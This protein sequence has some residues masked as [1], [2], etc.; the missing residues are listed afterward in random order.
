MIERFISRKGLYR[1]SMLLT[2]LMMSVQLMAQSPNAIIN[3]VNK[4]FARVHDYTATVNVSC[5]ISFIKIDPINARVYFKQPD[6]FKVKATGIL[7]MPKQNV[8]FYFTT[9]SD[10]GNYTAIRT[11]EEMTGGT[12]TQ[13][14]SIIPLQD[15]SDLVLGKFWIDDSRGLV[16]K[17]QLT[18]RSQG[19]ILIENS[20]GG[21]SAYALPDKM[22]FTVETGKF[23]I[24]KAIAAD[25]NQG[26]STNS[27][28]DGK[29]RITL[30]FSGY[31]INK[32]V[33]NEVF[34]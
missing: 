23:K 27:T 10:T 29:G 24:P 30:T 6:Q 19:T 31:V 22:I 33:S 5:D 8:N 9:L 20:Y 15:T 32:G 13:I 25:L 26:V 4:R 11:G 3:T 34:Q 21:A 7:I 17:S 14:I 12:K 2:A 28:A 1:Y 18:T 16:L